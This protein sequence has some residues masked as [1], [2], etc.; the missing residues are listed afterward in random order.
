MA[1]KEKPYLW[2]HDDPDLE[3]K[4]LVRKH[5]IEIAQP[6]TKFSDYPLHFLGLQNSLTV[7]SSPRFP[8]VSAPGMA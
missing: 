2:H 4:M 6:L 8:G 5:Q 3:G 1:F 7:L